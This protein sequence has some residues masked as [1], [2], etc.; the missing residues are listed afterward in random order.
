MCLCIDAEEHKLG[1]LGEPANYKD[2]LLDPESK[3]W[4]NA[5]NVEMKS[6]KDNEVWVLVELP[7][8]GKTIGSK[9][10]F[11][12]K[13]DMDGVVHTYKAH[14]VA[15]GYTQTPRI[16]YEEAFSLV[17]DIR[18]IRILIAIAAYYDYEIWKMDAKLPSSMDILMKR[19]TWS[20]LKRYCMENS[21]RGSIPMQ[22]K[23]MLSKS[24]GASTLAELNH[25]Q[26]VPYASAVGFIIYLTDVD[27]LKSQTGYVFILNGGA[28]DWK[29]AKKSI[30]A[31][32]SAEAEYITAFDASK[33][34]VWVRKF[35]SGLGVVPTIKEPIN[36]YCDN[37]RA[38]SIA[39]ESGIT[40]VARHFR[41]KVHYLRELIEYG[42]VK[43]EKVH[44][45][46]NLADPFT[47]AL[48]FPKHSEHT[49]NI[50]MLPASSLVS[51]PCSD[52]ESFK[53]LKGSRLH[54][55][56]T[57]LRICGF[58][59]GIPSGLYVNEDSEVLFVQQRRLDS[60][61]TFL[62][63]L[64]DL[65]S[66][67][68]SFHIPSC[69]DHVCPDSYYTAHDVLSGYCHL[70]ILNTFGVALLS[71]FVMACRAY[72]VSLFLRGLLMWSPSFIWL[73]WHALGRVLL[74][75]RLSLLTVMMTLRDFLYFPGNR[76]V[77]VA[78]VLDS[79]PLSVRSPGIHAVDLFDEDV[80]ILAAGP[81]NENVNAIAPHA[82]STI[83]TA[84]FVQHWAMSAPALAIHL[85]RE[86]RLWFLY[87]VAR[88]GEDLSL[89]GCSFSYFMGSH[90]GLRDLLAS[91]EETREVDPF[92]P[93]A[94][95]SNGILS[96]LSYSETQRHLDGLTLN[97]LANFHDVSALRFAMSNN[98]LN[99][100]AWSFS[101]E[102]SRLHDEVVTL[103]NQRLDSVIV[104]SKLEAKL[105]G[106]E[107]ESPKR[108]IEDD[109]KSLH[110]R[111][112]KFEENKVL[113]L[114][115]EASLK[116]ELEVFKEKLDFANEDRS[117]MVTDLLPRAIKT[118]LS[119]DSFG[120]MLAGLQEKDVFV[121]R[122][123]ALREVADLGIVLRLEDMRDY[124]PDA[125][126]IYDKAIDGFYRLEYPYLY[127]LAYHAKKSF[128]LL[129]TLK[130]P[131]PFPLHRSSGDGPFSSPFI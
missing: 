45:A 120:A 6:M 65:L 9:W 122:G 111:C 119:S 95:V 18:A 55:R 66:T 21:K 128:G 90:I 62:P 121:S 17:A 30:F 85:P 31:T 51:K 106:V 48:A 52:L 86:K 61:L 131:P 5:M 93:E 97:E 116:A 118:L 16:D 57:S 43:L 71:S 124:E 28:V 89:W 10:F 74:C 105:L 36:M 72:E 80:E 14:L 38:I 91:S 81:T 100:E 99:R 34:A 76:L 47:K 113:L 1:D 26:N 112:R 77:T 40:K 107:V 126:D 98:M 101:G 64:D 84:H 23:L 4:L 35:I 20:N 44:T 3:K 130:P 73:G 22:E 49:R 83:V 54:F 82:S 50:R 67:L 104:I 70:P 42:D 58:P 117:L 94:Q 2:A 19:F 46:D 32:S 39:N 33:E 87:L 11:K 15:N 102:V 109:T 59:Y 115:T 75:I 68:Q 56:W 37:I 24:Q 12:K 13:T 88:K 8:N 92:L 78:A 79:T 114:A 25:M 7:P 60:G 127:L 123:Q 41:A 103:R 96:G 29:S 129:K 110:S 53:F 69:Y 125:E 108:I 63:Y 27:D